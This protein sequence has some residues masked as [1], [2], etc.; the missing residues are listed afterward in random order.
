[1][2][3]LQA[4]H[5]AG[6]DVAGVHA[7]AWLRLPGVRSGEFTTKAGGVLERVRA[8]HAQLGRRILPTDL[9]GQP[10]PLCAGGAPL[11]KARTGST[12]RAQALNGVARL[13]R[14]QVRNLQVQVE[15][16]G[17][18]EA[19]AKSLNINPYTLGRALAGEPLLPETI[20]RILGAK[21]LPPDGDIDPPGQADE[22]GNPLPGEAPGQATIEPEPPPEHQAQEAD[23]SDPLLTK[24]LP[25]LEGYGRKSA[26]AKAIGRSPSCVCDWKKAG[27]IPEDSRPAVESWL[28]HPP[29]AVVAKT[30]AK[31]VEKKPKA[32]AAKVAAQREQPEPMPTTSQMRGMIAEAGLIALGLVVTE[33]WLPEGETM[34]KVRVAVLP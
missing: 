30:T 22:P 34:R 31:A 15:A 9:T 6:A 28:E 33:A 3:D 23:M 14:D 19:V 21:P 26:F 1:M 5:A 7:D 32:K 2:I 10:V 4:L 11:D 13:T 12:P 29:T 17:S 25:A 16:T 18:R 24:L 8:M 20:A 27:K